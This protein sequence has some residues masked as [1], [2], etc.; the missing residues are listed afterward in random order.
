[1]SWPLD[2]GAYA[3]QDP[4]HAWKAV[5][6]LSA[7]MASDLPSGLSIRVRPVC[8]ASILLVKDRAVELVADRSVSEH[9]PL[10]PLSRRRRQTA[11]TKAT[12]LD[13]QIE[14][15]KTVTKG[16]QELDAFPDRPIPSLQAVLAEAGQGHRVRQR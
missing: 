14:I 5:Y 9:S 13:A 3:L 15:E 1:M 2:L 4:P 8:L 7:W 10:T 16:S 6:R 11:E 12:F